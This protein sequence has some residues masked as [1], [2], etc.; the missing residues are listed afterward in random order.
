MVVGKAL[1]EIRLW[2]SSVLLSECLI[3]FF[4]L[5][6]Y[7]TMPLLLMNMACQQL[8]LLLIPSH[9]MVVT[10]NVRDGQPT[11]LWL[12]GSQQGLF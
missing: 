11:W 2:H 9:L 7:Y 6:P 8:E 1:F 3:R 12:C 4:F 5:V 10:V